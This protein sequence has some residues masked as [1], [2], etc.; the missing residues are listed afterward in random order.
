MYDRTTNGMR[1]ANSLLANMHLSSKMGCVTCIINVWEI[2][3]L[4]VTSKNETTNSPIHQFTS[5]KWRP[6]SLL[7]PLFD[8]VL[9]LVYYFKKHFEPCF[10]ILQAL[11]DILQHCK[12]VVSF[13]WCHEQVTCYAAVVICS[14]LAFFHI[15]WLM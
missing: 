12:F 5:L 9:F 2:I 14:A 15:M 6:E 11:K 4:F 1:Y 7:K 13:F 3:N 10:F 8:G